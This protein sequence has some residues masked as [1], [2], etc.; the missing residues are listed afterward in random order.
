M[1][2]NGNQRGGHGDLARHL[3]KPEN[4]HVE[5][6]EIRGFV[7][8]TVAGAF[9]EA[10]AIS[11]GTKCTQFLYSLSLSP[12]AAEN[13]PVKVFE[14]AIDAVESKLG[15][16]GQPR[17]IVFH[18]KQGRR[19]A[20]CVWSRIDADTMTAVK[21]PHTKLKLRDV[22]RQLFIRHGWQMPDGLVDR[23]LRNPL[24]FDRKEWFQARRVKQDPRD[25]KGLFQ[26]CWSAADSGKAFK[27]AI[28][29]RG[30][31]LARGDRRAVVALD[32]HGE[33]YAVARWADVKTKDVVARMGDVSALPSV[34]ETQAKI[35]G[36]VRD[37][38]TGFIGSAVSDF[39]Q[40]A[41]GIEAKRL[42]MAE[43]HRADRR[44]LQAAQ[45]ERW[46]KEAVERGTRFR[47]G[48]R[49]LWDRL[50]GQAAK[51]RD[52]NERETTQAAERDAR[53]KQALIERQLDERRHLQRE[54]DHTRRLHTKDMAMLYR[55]T[56]GPK[57]THD[58]EKPRQ[59]FRQSAGLRL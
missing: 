48:I 50:T 13:V 24:N 6:H 28:E 30:Y 51:L 29:E 4:E 32:V 10:H 3:M 45:D 55:Q 8:E 19:H 2:L 47:R 27:H 17:V 14:D 52:Q 7:S 39:A 53:E 35:A 40:A 16:S 18:E 15:L 37:K 33:I 42:A 34:E 56:S 9:K 36:L 31:Y 20:H 11:R 44:S 21:L 57:L 25:I 1:I 38:L 59:K 46:T 41:Q 12:P 54:I 43:R 26:Q 49:G 5:V 58:D 22:S 23:S